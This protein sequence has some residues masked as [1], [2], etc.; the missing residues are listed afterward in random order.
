MSDHKFDALV[1]ALESV[2]D[3]I[4]IYPQAVRG[5][6]DE[7]DYEQRD[8][9]KN[10]WNA[11]I[12]EYGQAFRKAVVAASDMDDDVLMLLAS[13]MVS[14]RRDGTTLWINFNDTWAWA[15]AD[16]EV[17]TPEDVPEVARL[18]RSWGWAGLL[19][20]ATTKHPD[21]RS[22]FKDNNRFIDFV[23][24]EEAFRKAVPDSSTRAYMD[25]PADAPTS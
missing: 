8:G 17:V 15:C 21:L 16:G 12:I 5:Y 24:R 2:G 7:R 3:D 9:Y 19:Y 4:G 14:L 25:L 1:K 6:N 20:W 11:A 10:G 18:F 22:E 23:A 13:D